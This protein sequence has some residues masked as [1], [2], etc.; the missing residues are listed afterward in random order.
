MQGKLKRVAARSALYIVAFILTIGVLVALYGISVVQADSG[1]LQLEDLPAGAVVLAD[2]F[3]A[4]DK[5]FHPLSSG[6]TSSLRS[7]F[8]NEEQG[9]LFGYKAVHS[10]A[11]LA[12]VQGVVV[13]NF[14]Y[15]YATATEAEQAANVLRRDVEGAATLLQVN[16]LK[17]AKGFRG[18]GFLLKGDE[19]DSVYWFVG[20]RGKNLVL[21]MVNGMEQASVSSVFESTMQRLLNK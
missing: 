3:L 1:I 20:I 16:D 19:G 13:M 15:E 12:P 7:K 9:L 17:G 6:Q 21:L 11:A 2:D 5:T 8:S 4:P 10:F 14:A 18:Q